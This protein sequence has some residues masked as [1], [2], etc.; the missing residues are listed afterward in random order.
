M[1]AV[2]LQASP[3][4]RKLCGRLAIVGF[5]EGTHIGGSL[6][7]AATNL[8][9]DTTK[10]DIADAGRGSQVLRAAWW[11]FGDRR[12]PRMQRFCRSVVARCR[13]SE[14]EIVIATGAAPLTCA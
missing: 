13:Q 11:R 4:A 1:T 14:P 2:A 3:A 5:F 10:F 6:W 7:R 8:G 9:I 12:L